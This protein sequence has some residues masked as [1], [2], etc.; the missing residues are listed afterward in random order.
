MRAEVRAF[1]QAVID[2]LSSFSAT[3]GPINPRFFPAVQTFGR[4]CRL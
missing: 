1:V 3:G 4:Q 2:V